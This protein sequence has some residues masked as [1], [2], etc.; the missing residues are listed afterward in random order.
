MKQQTALNIEQTS[1]FFGVSIVQLKLL[2]SGEK[3]HQFTQ[4]SS[5]EDLLA[6]FTQQEH[7][8]SY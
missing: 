7:K 4:C 6:W 5:E 8:G 3:G 1:C 2:S